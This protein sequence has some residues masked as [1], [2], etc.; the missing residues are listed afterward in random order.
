MMSEYST[1]QNIIFKDG[2]LRFNDY[3][4]IQILK[5][6]KKPITKCVEEGT[7]IANHEGELLNS[8]S[9]WHQASG[10]REAQ[11]S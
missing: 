2:I 6:F 8:K 7:L 3:F 1:V 11:M 5:A 9:E 4:T 10:I